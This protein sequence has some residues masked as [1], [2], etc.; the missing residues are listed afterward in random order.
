MTAT[1]KGAGEAGELQRPISR[2]AT[3]S[4]VKIDEVFMHRAPELG[5]TLLV[6]GRPAVVVALLP[7]KHRHQATARCVYDLPC[8]RCGARAWLIIVRIRYAEDRLW[9]AIS[10]EAYGNELAVLDC[11]L[12]MPAGRGR[13]R[14]GRRGAPNG[15]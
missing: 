13:I 14:T 3:V 5:D 10:A 12:Q 9:E 2:T 8:D 11:D 7:G 1:A 15:R 6:Y 4:A